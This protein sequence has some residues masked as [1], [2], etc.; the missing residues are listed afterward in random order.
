M[1]IAAPLVRIDLIVEVLA[2]VI[3]IVD[4][5]IAIRTAIIAMIDVTIVVM[6]IRAH[7]MIDKAMEVAKVESDHLVT[8][9]DMDTIVQVICHKT[10]HR[11]QALAFHS[12]V[13]TVA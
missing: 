6:A 10:L 8:I 1:V 5:V 13:T 7:L 11:I 12:P 4:A 3:L 9:E 2:V